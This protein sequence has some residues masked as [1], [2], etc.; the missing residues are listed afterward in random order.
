MIIG[1]E[2]KMKTKSIIS[3]IIAC[4]LTLSTT[5][6]VF[7]SSNLVVDQE[8]SKTG[9]IYETVSFT[10]SSSSKMDPKREFEVM[11]SEVPEFKE[12]EIA[13]DA[14]ESNYKMEVRYASVFTV[15]QNE[16]RKY[17][18]QKYQ[19]TI[20]KLVAMAQNQGIELSANIDDLELQA[21]AK[22]QFLSTDDPEI[23]SFVKFIDI[24]EN[25]AYNDTMRK[26]VA[27][28]E[29]RSFSTSDELL[30][31]DTLFNLLN[32]MPVTVDS[33]LENGKIGNKIN[34]SSKALSGYSS[35]AAIDYAST[36]WNRTNN[37]DYGYYA[38]Y[39]NHSDPTNNE[40]WSGGSGNNRRTWQDCANFVS[41]C[42]AAGGAEQI[43]SGL[44]LPHQK[45]ENW[46]YN[47]SKP[48]HTWGG[49]SNFFNH[50][51]D[52]VGVR[53][54]ASQTK[55]GDPVSVDYGGDNVPDHTLII[56]SVSGTSTSN[57]KY[58]CHTSDQFEASGKSL[59][60][61]YDTSEAVWVYNVG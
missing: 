46:Y 28:L 26:M 32:M 55:K 38:N 33:T 15:S 12:I 42:L 54:A 18:Y 48:S 22:E 31:D 27:D 9:T 7:A 6:P 49:A 16:A 53:S 29:A 3:V 2:V 35:T 58:A 1:K 17:G 13:Q 10:T 11:Q 14:S 45:T 21:Y 40:M 36:W 37:S 24:Y 39:Y 5:M 25:Y 51:S 20:D 57:M 19:K 56:T 43:K 41:Q 59:R 30:R 50:W 60:T 34:A 52:R 8:L 23:I 47:D 61:V 4:I 44:I